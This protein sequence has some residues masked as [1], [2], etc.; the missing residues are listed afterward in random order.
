MRVVATAGSPLPAEGYDYVYEQLGPDVLLINGSGGTDV[1]SAIVSG[2]PMLP[3][4]PR[5]DRRPLPGRRH[6]R[7]RPRRQRGRRRARRARDPAADAVDAGALLGRRA[8]A[9]AT[10]SSYFDVYPGVWRQGDW[11]RFS[12]AGTCII[13]GRSDATLNRGGVRMGTSELYT[14]VEEL[15]EVSGQPRRAPR[16]R[17]GRRRASCVLFVVAELDERR[18][19]RGSRARCARS[20]RRATCRTRSPPSRRSRARSP[21]RSSRRRSSGSCAAP[22]PR[23]VASRGALAEPA[24][25]RCVRAVQ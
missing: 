15:P 16:G 17:R 10:A 6:R 8:T 7:V 9:S 18:C 2:G 14:V 22:P 23:S 1:C 12:E 19:G 11:V 3:V 25:Y 4:L 21:A 13:T 24:R 20:S 5:R